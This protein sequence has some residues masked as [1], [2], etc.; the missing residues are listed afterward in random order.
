MS[1]VFVVLHLK[2]HKKCNKTSIE[3]I[4][5]NSVNICSHRQV[6]DNNKKNR[7]NNE[8]VARLLA[9]NGKRKGSHKNEERYLFSH[10][11]KQNNTQAAL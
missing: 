3:R 1:C 10:M 11:N 7:S 5:R 6:I 2:E 8:C 4:L 9:M